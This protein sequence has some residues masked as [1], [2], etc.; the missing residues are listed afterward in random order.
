MEDKDEKERHQALQPAC[1]I[2]RP[3]SRFT[4]MYSLNGL[5]LLQN[6]KLAMIFVSVFLTPHELHGTRN[7]DSPPARPRSLRAKRMFYI[8][9]QA[10]DSLR[11]AF[12]GRK[13]PCKHNLS[14]HQWC[15]F[16]R[17]IPPHLLYLNLPG[18][19]QTTKMPSLLGN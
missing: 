19:P 10:L 11:G 3:R 5:R 12:K 1:Q 7:T 14:F 15:P 8:D 18:S 9:K 13:E 6:G 16:P 4:M 17:Q 2:S